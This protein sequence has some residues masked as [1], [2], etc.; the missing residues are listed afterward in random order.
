M[1][2]DSG[3]DA[4]K[5][6]SVDPGFYFV[7]QPI[8]FQLTLHRRLLDA[9]Q[10]TKSLVDY[11]AIIVWAKAYIGSQSQSAQVG[12]STIP[13]DS[14]SPRTSHRKTPWKKEIQATSPRSDSQLRRV[15]NKEEWRNSNHLMRL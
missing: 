15:S 6:K 11:G 14:A 10:L 7:Q 8:A 5:K 4:D 2:D 9:M 3:L 1:D 13:K 12:P